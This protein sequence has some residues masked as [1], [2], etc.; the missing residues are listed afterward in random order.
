MKRLIIVLI[1]LGVLGGGGYY[2]YKQKISQ[3]DTTSAWG[4]I[5]S[6]AIYVL[7]ASDPVKA[8][9]SF[10]QSTFW[11]FL[12]NHPYLNELTKDADYLDEIMNEHKTSLKFLGNRTFYMSAH[13]TAYNNYDYLFFVD[14]KNAGILNLANLPWKRL[15]GGDFNIRKATYNT[16]EIVQI[17]DLETR[18]ILYLTQV[19]NYLVCSYTKDLL[20]K[21]IEKQNSTSFSNNPKF[22]EAYGRTSASGLAQF[23]IQYDFLDEYFG[24]YT[25]GNEETL[26]HISQAFQFT[27][28]DMN[29]KDETALLEGYTSLPEVDSLYTTLVQQYGNASM[30]FATVLSSRTAYA[31]VI[32]LN[33]FKA[34]YKD[35]LAVRSKNPESLEE[36]NEV[37]NRIEK[38]LGLSIEQDILTWIGNEIVLAQNKPSYLHKNEDDLVVAIKAYNVD[39]AKEKL[40]EIQKRI[41]RRT[42]AKFKK[43]SYKNNHIYYLDIKGFFGIFFG[44]AFDKLTKPY[45][46]IIDDF[47]V[48][49]NSP[50]TLVSTIEDYENGNVLANYPLFNKVRSALPEDCAFFTYLNGP[51]SY[52]ALKPFVKASE[53]NNYAKN[54]AYFNFFK[55]IGISY[56]SQGKGFDNKIFLSFN[57][58]EIIEEPEII[59][60]DSLVNAYLEDYSKQLNELEDAEK[61]VLTEIEDGLFT[62]YYSGTDLV[63]Y[64]AETKK[65]KFHGEFKEYYS[66]GAIRSEGKY[67]KGRKVGRWKY[68]NKEGDL[69]EKDWEGF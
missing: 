53:Q 22:T 36:Y 3:L 56:T 57:Q 6:D 48:F 45:Y 18:D 35:L 11:Q 58:Q 69:T 66:T 21:C 67:R 49:S 54:K 14:L 5:P 4:I 38:V 29:L 64:T 17:I 31:Q 1:L 65:G 13:M 40:S 63:H 37:K 7:E 26:Q 16:N 44:K 51:N 52:T 28:L 10:S 61:F 46:T 41:K 34:F 43:L 55:G 42:P 2:L 47:I 39:Y 50:K 27:C 15:L 62:K 33:K 19:K 24:V 60:L 25:K 12:K 59:N 9:H 30:E 8:W 32:A 23:Y 68:Y 20:T